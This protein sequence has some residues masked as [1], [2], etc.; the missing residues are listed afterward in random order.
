MS[1]ALAIASSNIQ[2]LVGVTV[3]VTEAD[4][5]ATSGGELLSF[6]GKVEAVISPARGL[7][8]MF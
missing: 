5:I 3:D 4:L 8:D 7:V 6:D 1:D 2:K